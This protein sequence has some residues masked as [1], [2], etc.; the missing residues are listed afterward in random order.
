[1]YCGVH[2]H[3]LLHLK[4]WMKCTKLFTVIYPLKD[5]IFFLSLK[6]KKLII[7]VWNT[8]SIQTLRQEKACLMFNVNLIKIQ[9]ST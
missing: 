5:N 3:K 6:K 8:I 9:V 1:M 2:L 4:N 7:N